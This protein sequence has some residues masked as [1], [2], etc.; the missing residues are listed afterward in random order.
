MVCGSTLLSMRT[1]CAQFTLTVF[2]SNVARNPSA[3]LLSGFT[4]MCLSLY[5][6]SSPPPISTL[7]VHLVHHGLPRGDLAQPPE[8]YQRKRSGTEQGNRTPG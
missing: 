6:S 8:D 5:Q 7:Q 4:K 3:C 2:T 1:F